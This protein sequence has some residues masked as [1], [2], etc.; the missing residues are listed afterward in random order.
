MQMKYFDV[1]FIKQL[2]NIKFPVTTILD[3]TV[4]SGY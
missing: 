2:V 3:I 4:S 1:T